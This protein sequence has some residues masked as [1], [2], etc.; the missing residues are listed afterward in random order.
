MKTEIRHVD[1]SENDEV[2]PHVARMLVQKL[3]G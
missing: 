3:L 2:E 1:T